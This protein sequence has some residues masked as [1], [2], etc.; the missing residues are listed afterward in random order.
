M[1]RS[2]AWVPP[3]RLRARRRRFVVA[4]GLV[5]LVAGTLSVGVGLD[6]GDSPPPVADRGDAGSHPPRESPA[7]VVM[8]QEQ[9]IRPR[10]MEIPHGVPVRLV[11]RND[12]WAQHDFIVDRV[13]IHVDVGPGERRGAG[14][15]ARRHGRFSSYCVQP[16]HRESVTVVVV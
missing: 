1:R 11:V 9:A 10:R 13:G 4:G 3:S 7:V 15:M 2:R 14:V 5:L 12:G 6:G 16:G 8:E